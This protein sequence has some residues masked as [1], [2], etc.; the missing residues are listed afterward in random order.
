[1]SA[2]KLS[3]GTSPAIVS[4]GSPCLRQRASRRSASKNPS[5]PIAPRKS[6]FHERATAANYSIIQGSLDARCS[7][8]DLHGWALPRNQRSDRFQRIALLRKPRKPPIRV[9]KS[10]LPHPFAPQN[11]VLAN[12]IRIAPR[13]SQFFEVPGLSIG[14]LDHR[15]VCLLKSTYFKN[16]RPFPIRSNIGRI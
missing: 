13:R 8:K 15:Q 2:R 5:C 3:L 6:S 11:H 4:S 14:S 10:Q 16:D 7:G 12:E 1:M 9:E